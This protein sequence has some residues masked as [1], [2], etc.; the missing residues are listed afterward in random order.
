MNDVKRPQFGDRQ[1]LSVLSVVLLLTLLAAI[2]GCGG[3]RSAPP[4]TSNVPASPPP[5]T[6]AGIMGTKSV[7]T[8]FTGKAVCADLTVAYVKGIGTAE[9]PANLRTASQVSV[10]MK[11]PKASAY[12]ISVAKVT[13]TA[14]TF[15][16]TDPHGRLLRTATGR[17]PFVAIALNA[18]YPHK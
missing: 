17:A 18:W 10:G 3:S 14:V 9:L 16:V 15:E 6:C 11:Q 4:Q 7:P 13:R 8:N 2:T 12:L 5:E 1:I